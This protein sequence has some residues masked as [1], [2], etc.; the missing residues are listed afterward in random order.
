[1]TAPTIP[2]QAL[3]WV[4]LASR[5]APR[6]PTGRRYRSER[7]L[8][9]PVESL[10]LVETRLADGDWLLAGIEPDRLR[11]HLVDRS[12][13]GR[14]TWWLVPDAIPAHLHVPE[15]ETLDACARLNLLS[16]AF[17]PASH[18]SRRR[19]IDIGGLVAA[20][21]MCAL[22]VIGV[23]RRVAAAHADAL[24]VQAAAQ[25]EVESV[26]PALGT[27]TNPTARLT[28]ELRRLEQVARSPAL[29]NSAADAGLAIEALLARWPAD[30]RAQIETLSASPD[31]V[32]LRGRVPT[33]V[34]AER[35]AQ[36]CPRLETGTRSWSAQ[37]LQAQQGANGAEFSLSWSP[38]TR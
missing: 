33:L 21:L 14:S 4:R 22:I 26:V 7:V 11:A 28:M 27:A 5:E 13:I 2:T 15:A 17:E 32:I 34:D 6:S 30:V 35:I 10:H 16:G 18:R 36:A 23:E 31:R 8:P 29:A 3:Y 20:G 12:D 37:P 1:M 19:L 25:T 38:E 24:R 9:V